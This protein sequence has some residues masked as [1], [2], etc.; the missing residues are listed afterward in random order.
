MSRDFY[1]ARYEAAKATGDRRARE[2]GWDLRPDTRAAR[3]GSFIGHAAAIFAC[4]YVWFSLV[5]LG[6]CVWLLVKF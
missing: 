5:P 6:L 2:R 1:D 4:P 3:I